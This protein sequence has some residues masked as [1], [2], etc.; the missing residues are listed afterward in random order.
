M[1]RFAAGLAI[2]IFAAIL[3]VY[4]YMANTSDYES[5]TYALS[6]ALDKRDAGKDLQQRIT[7]IRRISQEIRFVQKNEL[8]RA[9]DI[10]A[11]RL[12]L[13]IVGQPLIRG[14]NKALARY[15]FRITGPS[16]FEEANAVLK[17]M[18]TLPGFVPYSFCFACSAPPRG[19]PPE[20]SMVQIEG[21]IYAYD[22]D[23]LY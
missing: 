22:K 9:L 11:P 23:T 10:G 2:I 3:G 1:I 7:T 4:K 20:L 17:R 12:D 19:A 15:V 18:A 5:R 13:R 6:D 16:T 21:Y 14:N 8:E